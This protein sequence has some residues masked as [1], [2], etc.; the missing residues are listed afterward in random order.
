M[1]IGRA[2]SKEFGNIHETENFIIGDLEMILLF[3][4]F[5]HKARFPPKQS[6]AGLCLSSQSYFVIFD[7]SKTELKGDIE[8]TTSNW[9]LKHS[10]AHSALVETGPYPA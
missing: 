6:G 7:I 2:N 9:S 8:M 3:Q 4:Q 10:S 5:P 1:T